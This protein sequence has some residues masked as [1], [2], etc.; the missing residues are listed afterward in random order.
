MAEL[1]M[2]DKFREYV[3]IQKSGATNMFHV[4]AVVELSNSRLTADDCYTIMQNYESYE[5]RWGKPK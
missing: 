2:R 5:L 1:T 3:R 4:S